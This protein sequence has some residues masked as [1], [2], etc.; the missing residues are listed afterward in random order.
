MDGGG[1]WGRGRIGGLREMFSSE[2]YAFGGADPNPETTNSGLVNW[3]RRVFS[4]GGEPPYVLE[5]VFPRRKIG[6]IAF[7]SGNRRATLIKPAHVQMQQENCSDNGQN[8]KSHR[9]A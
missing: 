1:L 9:N 4:E 5:G 6:C 3:T 8:S 2:S 7:A